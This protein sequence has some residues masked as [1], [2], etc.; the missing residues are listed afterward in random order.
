MLSSK[1]LEME[2]RVA[3]TKKIDPLLQGAIDMHYHG[4]PEI[5]LGVKA[6]LDDVAV[7][8]LAKNMGMRG[9]VIKSQMWPSMGRTHFLNRL[10]P[11][12]EC[13]GSITLN[14][15]AGGISPWV[16]E[17]AA[18][19]GAKVVWLPT[20]SSANKL[21][22][23]GFSRFMKEWFPTIKF[24]PGLSCVDASG[25]LTTDMKSII[26]LAKEM[27][28]VLC[29]S[30]IA[31]TES[32]VVAEEAERVGFDRLVFTHP[33]S[34]SVGATLEQT[35]EMVKRGAYVEL[36]ALN[37][38][39]A[40]H[41]DKMLQFIEEIGPQ[42]CILSTDAFMEWVP[43]GPEY[44]RMFIGRLFIAGVGEEGIRA[45]VRDNPA[46]LLGLTPIANG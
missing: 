11:D 40:N 10:V 32:L 45:M 2:A 4:Y 23:D 14:S 19:Q 18:R 31:P 12:I 8:E 15:V 29:T 21:G 36:I 16:V 7:L 22:Q 17:A 13:F 3:D 38:F 35:K 39:Y 34:G 41:L 20:W 26:A 43:P 42:R 44:L 46:K 25:K 30:H 1:D 5:T 24:E 33:L 37:I 6:R 27:N 28:L 9:I